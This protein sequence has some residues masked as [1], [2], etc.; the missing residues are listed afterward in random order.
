MT[1]D[2]ISEEREAQRLLL[3]LSKADPRE[4]NPRLFFSKIPTADFTHF[5]QTDSP[6][7]SLKTFEKKISMRDASVSDRLTANFPE[8]LCT[9]SSPSRRGR[10]QT[11]HREGQ[12]RRL[13]LPAADSLRVRQPEA[14]ASESCEAFTGQEEV[15]HES[16]EDVHQQPQAAAVRQRDGYASL[17]SLRPAAHQPAAAQVAPAD[18]ERERPQQSDDPRHAQATQRPLG[19]QRQVPHRVHAAPHLERNHSQLAAAPRRLQESRSCLAARTGLQLQSGPRTQ[20]Q[21]DGLDQRARLA[22]QARSLQARPAGRRVRPAGPRL[23]PEEVAP[24]LLAAR[25]AQETPLLREARPARPQA[26]LGLAVP[27]PR[28]APRP[29]AALPHQQLQEVE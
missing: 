2:F 29:P 8:I 24:Q 10:P 16:A 9:H 1:V 18:R 13:D 15:P 6:K 19:L 25:A 11:G 3:S 22:R 12:G 5:V 7:V 17:T 21:P 26:P 27:L 23:R 20:P 4:P 28:Q 14:A